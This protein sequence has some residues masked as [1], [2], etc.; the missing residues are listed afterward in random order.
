MI[1]YKYKK[2]LINLVLNNIRV[3]LLNMGERRS[4]TKGKILEAALKLFSRKGFRETTVKDIAKEVGITEGAIYRHFNS[5]D[6]II[7]DLLISITT[8]LKEAIA[9]SIEKGESEEEIFK[10]IIETLIDYAFNKPESYRFLNLYHLLKEYPQVTHLPGE[11]ILKFLN[12]LYAKKKL[13]TY[14]EVALAVVTGSVE[15]TFIFKERNFIKRDTQL[16][17]IELVSTLKKAL[18]G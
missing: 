16:I 12:N 11:Q 15:R 13:K 14:P 10:N 4:D 9:K 5:K 17:K 18:I 8:E 6:E 2:F 1:V 3:Y 7:H